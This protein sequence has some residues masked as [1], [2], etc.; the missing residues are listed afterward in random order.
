V[1]AGQKVTAAKK[2]FY[3]WAFKAYADVAT[4]CE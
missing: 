1:Y 3:P 4:F 2:P